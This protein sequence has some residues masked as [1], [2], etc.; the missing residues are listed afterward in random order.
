M[1]NYWNLKLVLCLS[2]SWT[3]LDSNLNNSSLG[4]TFESFFT[5]WV[6]LFSSFLQTWKWTR[7]SFT[8][9][10]SI[11]SFIWVVGEC[12]NFWLVHD[13]MF[14]SEK[15]KKEKAREEIRVL[16]LFPSLWFILFYSYQT[17]DTISCFLWRVFSFLL[18]SLLQTIY[19]PGWDTSFFH[20]LFFPSFFFHCQLLTKEK[21]KNKVWEKK[22]RVNLG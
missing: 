8:N 4:P 17:Q 13:V 11:E 7:N 21:E 19:R 6:L 15:N 20:T 12:L 14:G 5:Y 9:D 2:F 10:H 16:G 3:N 18:F 1:R 22:R